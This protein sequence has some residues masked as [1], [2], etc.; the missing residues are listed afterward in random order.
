MICIIDYGMGNLRSVEKAIANVGG[1]VIVSNKTEDIISADKLILPGVGA[2]KEAVAEL[3]KSGLDKLIIK[4]V[5]AGK[6]ILGICLGM[7]LL[8]TKSYEDGEYI[9]L[10][11]I[12]GEVVKF[13]ATNKIPQIG[14]NDF[15]V[16]KDSP[17]F[18]G[19]ENPVAYFVHS[20][21]VPYSE[22]T[23]AAVTEYGVKY[24]SIV[25]KD[26]IIGCQ[27]HPEK[28]GETGLQLLRNF[29]RM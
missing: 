20:Y 2:I 17:F 13:S 16:V 5:K 24:A 21:Y 15:K 8:M 28:S 29:V 3:T 6:P 12:E 18:E 11:L 1:E 10:G 7:Q 9:G 4:Q 14:W 26:N 19:I 25:M 23:A 27:F 22:K